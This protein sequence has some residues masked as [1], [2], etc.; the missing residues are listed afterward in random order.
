MLCPD[1]ESNTYEFF[2]PMRCKN[3]LFLGKQD[4]FRKQ[5]FFASAT[6]IRMSHFAAEKKFCQKIQYC[7]LCLLLIPYQCAKLVEQIWRADVRVLHVE[8]APFWDQK[9][10]LRKIF[11]LITFAY[12]QY[13]SIKRNFRKILNVYSENKV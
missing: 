8:N 2:G 4:F 13:P 9:D 6:F 7:R 5:D 3:A 11:S 12:L 10:F 1:L